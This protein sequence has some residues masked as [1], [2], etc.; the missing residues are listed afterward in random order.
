MKA[1]WTTVVVYE[2]R[3]T[4]DA[5]VNFCDELVR[6]FWRDCEVDV[7]WCS[8]SD[9]EEEQRAREASEKAAEADLIVF[10]IRPAEAISP[11]LKGWVESWLEKRGDREGKMIGLLDQSGLGSGTVNR[12][13]FLRSAAHR[14]GM[15]YLTQIADGLA[16]ATPESLDAYTERTAQVTHV[17]DDILRQPVPPRDMALR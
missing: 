13:V 16:S 10:A 1:K 14:S 15:D 11:E 17:L 7:D 2:D 9:L 6:R 3:V 5:A 8:L 4:R 12:Y